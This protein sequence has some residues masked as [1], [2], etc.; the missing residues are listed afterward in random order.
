[1][2]RIRGQIAA[3]EAEIAGY[4]NENA[5]ALPTLRDAKRDEMVS[6]DNDLRRL[7]QDQV[8]LEGEAAQINAKQSLRETDRR[9]LE[10]IASR[11]AV[12][13]AQIA[14]S[15]AR[16][17]ELEADLST[18][19]EVERVLGGY[20][21]QMTQLQ[22]QFDS[23]NARMTDAETEAR[24]AV[25]QQAERFTL[26]ERAIVPE[27]AIGGGNRKI[28]IA[29]A[30]ASLLA[31]VGLAFG[32]DLARPV[33]RSAAQMERQ[34]DLRPVI[35]IPEIALPKKARAGRGLIKMLDDPTKPLLG[36]PRFAVIAAGA[37]LFLIA[38]AAMV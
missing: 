22:T 35:S 21:R 33:V 7:K 13:E 37:T 34:L 18:S 9:A 24:L 31:A 27:S 16:R 6:L 3:L 26:L 32:M 30:L 4:K 1:M 28:A 19:P 5:A 12:L 38:A 10:D 36:L 29:G 8:A 20:E 2:A 23:A 17:S 25:R 14:A 11:A 15:Q